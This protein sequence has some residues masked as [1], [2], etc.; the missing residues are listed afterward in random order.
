MIHGYIG[1]H[2]EPW[3]LAPQLKKEYLLQLASFLVKVRGEVIDR[4]EPDLGDT[5]LS[6]GM[7][8]YECCRKRIIFKNDEGTW[9]WLSVLTEQGRFTFAID[10]VPVRFT[11]N[12]PNNL[13]DRKLIPSQEG[14]EQMSLFEAVNDHSHLR[15]FF[16]IDTPYD[17]PAENAFLIGYSE[18][19]EIVCKWT[20]PLAD[21]IFAPGDINAK[22]PEPVKVEPAKAKLKISSKK[23]DQN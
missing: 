6:L 14:F 2:E 20:V 11:R 15:W 12:D 1:M 23:E 22:K 18:R 8:A 13:P 4:H 16:V 9:P 19:N 3:L 5:R 10:G 7:R 17:V 21:Q